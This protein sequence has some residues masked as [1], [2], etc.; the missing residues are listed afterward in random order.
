MMHDDQHGTAVVV[1]AALLNAATLVGKDLEGLKVVIA[2][3][4]AAGVVS[5]I[6]PERSP[7]APVAS[8]PRLSWFATRDRAHS[9][10]T[11]RRTTGISQA[12]PRFR[13]GV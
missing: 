10:A 8:M 11:T 9:A 1:L 6:S 3:A 13:S 5:W 12:R 7:A 2:G 4:G